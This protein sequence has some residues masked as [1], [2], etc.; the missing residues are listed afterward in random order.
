MLLEGASMDW[1][2]I[3]MRNIF[4]PGPFLSGIA[5]ASFAFFQAGTRFFADGFVERY[6]PMSVARTL[7][8]LLFGATLIVFFSPWPLLSLAGFALIGLMAGGVG[9]KGLEHVVERGVA[10]ERRFVL[11][12][13]DSCSANASLHCDAAGGDATAD[14]RS[15]SNG[16]RSLCRS[17]RYWTCRRTRRRESPP[18]PHR[19]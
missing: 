4:N 2:A 8:I 9:R 17:L 3:Y 14:A 7:L 15:R 16:P 18:A 12:A 6:S 1:S 5:V 11:T 13:D 10:H 19:R